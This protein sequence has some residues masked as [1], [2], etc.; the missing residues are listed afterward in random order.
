[1]HKKKRNWIIGIATLCTI[2]ML[3]SGVVIAFIMCRATV[4]SK[5][6]YA[7]T[8]G[9]F[10]IYISVNATT[11][12]RR[13][14]IEVTMIFKNLSGE[15]KEIRHHG[16]LLVSP[17]IVNSVYYNENRFDVASFT[18]LQEREERHST[19]K[20]GSFLRRGQH[21]LVATAV[22]SLRDESPLLQTRIVSNTVILTVR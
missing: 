14:D 13:Q 16:L 7:R 11:F 20:M 4:P 22:I 8:E 12:R 19:M 10:E 21:E 9:D 6:T 18:T 2:I 3:S 15:R 1:M 17:F 5:P